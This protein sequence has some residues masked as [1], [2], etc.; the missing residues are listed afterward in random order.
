MIESVCVGQ[1]FLQ[2]AATRKRLVANADSVEYSLEEVK[3]HNKETDCWTVYD[4]KVYDI[5]E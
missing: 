5:T 3:Q 4:G 2:Q 1:Q